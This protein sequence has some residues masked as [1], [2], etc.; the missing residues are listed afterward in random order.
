MC[1]DAIQTPMLVMQEDYDEAAIT[2]SGPDALTVE[3]IADALFSEVIPKAPLELTLP[4]HRGV[5]AK[6]G[7]AFP[8]ASFLL[9]NILKKQGKRK[10]QKRKEQRTH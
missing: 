5:L 7:S 1:P 10:Q 8:Q 9:G 3:N 4:W 2:F 6:I